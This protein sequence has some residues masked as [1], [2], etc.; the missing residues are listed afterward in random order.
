MCWAFNKWY[1]HRFPDAWCRA[2]QHSQH[3]CI[4]K[5]AAIHN[6]V[7]LVVS[8]ATPRQRVCNRMWN[9]P[10]ALHS[11][12]SSL[13]LHPWGNSL[14]CRPKFTWRWNPPSTLAQS[15]VPQSG[16]STQSSPTNRRLLW[17]Q[18][19][20]LGHKYAFFLS[21]ATSLSWCIPPRLHLHDFLLLLL[22]SASSSSSSLYSRCIRSPPLSL[23]HR[24]YVL[25]TGVHCLLF[26]FMWY[27]PSEIF[28]TDSLS[29][30]PRWKAKV[31]IRNPTN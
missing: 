3:I 2:H 6:T 10:T 16:K 30:R 23:L 5:T 17:G 18:R 27:A 7:L 13:H 29:W 24:R 9:W 1:N 25:S 14:M 12:L 20:N 4:K 21:S 22:L 31:L 19:G 11:R 15:V 26:C 28:P 8:T